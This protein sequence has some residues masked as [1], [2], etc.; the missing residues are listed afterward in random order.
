MRALIYI[1][2]VPTSAQLRWST[3]FKIM[4]FFVYSVMAYGMIAAT[5]LYCAGC[6]F[7]PSQLDPLILFFVGFA[8]VLS[9]GWLVEIA[10]VADPALERVRFR[11]KPDPDG[12]EFS[13]FANLWFNYPTFVLGMVVATIFMICQETSTASSQDASANDVVMPMRGSSNVRQ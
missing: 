6:R 1:P 4:L 9:V 5:S 11:L 10:V 7:V 3:K 2:G 13:R 8:I 12:A